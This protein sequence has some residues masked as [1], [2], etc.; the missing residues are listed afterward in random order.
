MRNGGYAFDEKI[1]Y[2]AIGRFERRTNGCN[3][4]CPVILLGGKEY[5]VDMQEMVVWTIL[6]WCIVK[7]EEVQDLYNK[8]V[9]GTDCIVTRSLE[10]CLER[11]LI[12]G[13]LVAGSGKTEYD[14]LYDLLSSLYIISTS[15]SFTVRILS[16]LKLTLHNRI[17][18]SVTKRLF[19]KD[20]RTVIEQQVMQLAGQALLSTAEII[21]C[22]D[23]DIRRLPNEESILSSLYN[24]E[25]TTCDNIAY[26]VKLCSCSQS[27]LLAVA[28]LYL[29]Q[30]VIFERI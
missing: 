22:V 6:N 3:R 19:H 15:G 10:D 18:I 11:L 9:L 14:A 29:R 13:L 17:P 24:D 21:K 2:T 23:H 8:T 25:D 12:R 7:K 1:L 5:M 4:S 26:L 20:K 28:N 16:F 27:V 30:Q